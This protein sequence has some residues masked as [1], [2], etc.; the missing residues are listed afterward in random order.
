MDST[1]DGANGQHSSTSRAP[2]TG[3]RRFGTTINL[4]RHGMRSREN[5]SKTDD[6]AK[7]VL[8]KPRP[9]ETPLQWHLSYH[10]AIIGLPQKIETLGLAMISANN[11]K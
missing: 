5:H 9:L 6:E 10:G 2:R 8:R 11:Q 1:R 7:Q 4:R 3:L